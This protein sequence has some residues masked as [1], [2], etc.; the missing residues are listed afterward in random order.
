VV[1][2]ALDLPFE[3]EVDEGWRLYNEITWDDC[4]VILP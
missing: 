4:V 2:V 1:V 3:A